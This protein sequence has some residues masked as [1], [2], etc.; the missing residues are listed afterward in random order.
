MSTVS[1]KATADLSPSAAMIHLMMGLWVSR[2]IYVTAKQ[3]IADL[4]KNNSK[5]VEELAEA[6]DTD[7]ASLYRVMR[8]MASVGIFVENDRSQFSLT[9]LGETLRSDVS[10]SLRA[11]VLMQSGEENYQAWGHLMHSVQTGE[12]AFGHVF[13][14]GQ[15]QYRAQNPEA[16]KVFDEA[17]AS[18]TRMSTAA[19]LS[20]YSFSRFSKIVDVGGGN[21]SLLAA[22]LKA[23]PAT[24]GVLF[25]LPHVTEKA[26]RQLANAGVAERC[27][28]IAGDAFIS[29]PEGGDAYILSRVIHDWDD[30][31]ATA[32]L[33][34]CRRAIVG[35]A[36]LLLLENV[37]GPVNAPDIAKFLDLTML[38]V[39]GGRERNEIEYRTLLEASGFT[40]TNH[41][42]TI[43]AGSERNR[44]CAR[45][46]SLVAPPKTISRTLKNASDTFN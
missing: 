5:T 30:A 9:P 39:A 40:L 33:K 25:D 35:N 37:V 27:E 36:K 2:A 19:V 28:V 6:T 12:P 20:S 34:N 15:W 23:T 1:E 38:V 44:V 41:S 11:W 3:G 16:A 7:A 13:G 14:M 42:D 45:W 29:V 32:I 4:L 43:R 26:K 46:R 22:I 31:R 21:G 24:K 17:M 10:G 18:L 8:A